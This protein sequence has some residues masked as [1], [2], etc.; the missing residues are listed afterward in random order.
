MSDVDEALSVDPAVVPLYPV[1]RLEVRPVGE[2]GLTEGFQDGEQVCPAMDPAAVKDLLVQRAAA[3]A[4][5]RHGSVRAVRAIAI[6]DGQ[7]TPLV[8]TAEGIAIPTQAVKKPGRGPRRWIGWGIGAAVLVT[9]MGVA[10]THLANRAESDLP[11]PA[12]THTVVPTPTPTQLPVVSPQGWASQAAWSAPLGEQGS[13]AAVVAVPGGLV[14]AP[15]ADG[16]GVVARRVVDGVQMWTAAAGDSLAYGP[17]YS[18]INGH[19]AIVAAT[20]DTLLAWS[21]STGAA[22]GTWSLPTDGSAT[23][24]SSP[25]G[26]VVTTDSQHA[27]IVSGPRLVARVVPAGAAPAVP[28]GAG[29]VV[30]GQGQQW[31]VIG[32]QLAPAST[33]LAAP[34]GSSWSAVAGATSSTLIVAYAP[35]GQSDGSFVVLRGFDLATGRVRWTTGSVPAAAASGSGLPLLVAPAQGWGLYGSSAVNLDSG[36]VT[37]LPGDWQTT[38]VGDQLAFGTTAGGVGQVTAAGTVSAPAGDPSAVDAASTSA[39]AP[40]AV[41]GSTAFVVAPDGQNTNLYA[42]RQGSR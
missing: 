19:P 8:V 18:Q 13:S 40:V 21:T 30:A 31:K 32:D 7:E 1:V 41:Q 2:E 3:V 4:A 10:G 42:I 9:G 23:V 24:T 34:A 12:V 16:T 17:A 38:A 11:Q 22:L 5:R 6:E 36:K 26:V 28:V 25:G 33:A 15:S 27:L 20:S 35:A 37:A 14:V 39:V 29:L